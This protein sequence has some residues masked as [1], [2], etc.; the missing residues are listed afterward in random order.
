MKS[1]NTLPEQV[2]YKEERVPQQH[3]VKMNPPT[4]KVSRV[5]FSDPCSLPS[6][7]PCQNKSRMTTPDQYQSMS[8][9]SP[10]QPVIQPCT[11]QNIPI[12]QAHMYHTNILPVTEL[13]GV[14]NPFLNNYGSMQS[15]Y[16]CGNFIPPYSP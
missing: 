6:P 1:V 14:N 7:R 12:T 15:M 9:Q 8:P 10:L 4:P 16:P 5:Q 11:E 3:T 13:E 2:P